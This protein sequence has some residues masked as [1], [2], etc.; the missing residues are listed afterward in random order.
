LKKLIMSPAIA[1]AIAL[2]GCSTTYPLYVKNLES[3]EVFVGKA[4]SQMFGQSDFSV[5]NPE[6][7]VC[8]G[9]YKA[10]LIVNAQEGTSSAGTLT[11]S[12]GRAG[13]WVVS[14][15]GVSGG[16]G[17]GK[18]D[19]KRIVIMYGGMARISSF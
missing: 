8:T 18:L 19:G 14:G 6:G 4:T 11:C 15:A 10:D 1:I 5:S 12:D 17:V 16:Q 9:K 7:V 13:T 2:V 3:S